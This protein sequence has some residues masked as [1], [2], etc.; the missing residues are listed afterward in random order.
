TL[1]ASTPRLAQ[2]GEGIDAGAWRRILETEGTRA[3][4]LSNAQA[5]FGPQTDPGVAEW[6]ADEGAKTAP[7]MV[8][9]LQGCLLAEDLTPLLPD[10]R[11]PTLLLAAR[12]DNITP[13]E[14]QQVMVGRIPNATLQTFDE[15]GHNMKVEIP[16][17]LAQR[18]REFIRQVE[19]TPLT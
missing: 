18:T 3:W 9:G 1:V 13:L 10:I 14:V 15:V 16:D 12:R 8:L 17:L 6:Y 7:E 19:S 5:R 2:M 11:C 4:L